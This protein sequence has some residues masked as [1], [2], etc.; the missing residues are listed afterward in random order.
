MSTRV[1]VIGGGRSS[2]HE[3]SLASAAGVADALREGGFDVVTLTVARDGLWWHDGAQLG[4]TVAATVAAAVLVLG[5][6]DAVVPM[7]HGR[8][9]E[10]GTLAALC[11]LA[12]LACVGSPLRAGALAMDKWVTK[13]VAHALGIDVA[14][15]RLI[16]PA[17]VNT[18]S[19]TAPVVVKPVAAGSSHGV[20]LV[21]TADGL[22]P[23][24]DRA[25]ALDDRV[26]IEQRV[27][28]QEVDVAVFRRADG[29]LRASAALEILTA[30]GVFD[31]ERKYGA[32]TVFR[33]PAQIDEDD[34]EALK[35]AAKA[36]YA[37]L[38]CEGVARFDFFLT[39]AGSVLNEVNTTPGATAK[40]QVP[41]MYAA[42]GLEF[43]NL[44]TA[45][46]ATAVM[47][48]EVQRTSHRPT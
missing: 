37:A 42:D 16:T 14:A 47:Q 22:A 11:D 44:V 17:D 26:L 32:D 38:G 28:G 18:V 7:V 45:L 12:G 15:G 4:T 46:V 25:F 10:D 2:E 21:T 1:A 9:G 24:L 36:L 3:V 33:C 30:G 27:I 35:E 13:L 29:T 31:T 39:D 6:V 20:S 43:P 40:S 8:H 23:A 5:A 34:A 48:H 41:V 19:W